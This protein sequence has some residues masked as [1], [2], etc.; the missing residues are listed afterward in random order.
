MSTIKVTITD[1]Q[2]LNLLTSAL[3]GG[4]NYWYL[5]DKDA[6][7]IIDKHFPPAK[8]VCFVDRMWATIK[9]GLS[10]PIADNEEDEGVGE[11][12][13]ASI[14]KGEQLLADK[15][16]GTLAEILEEND[17]A[18]TADIWFQLCSFGE[19]IYG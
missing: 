12:S 8:N 1:E 10:I 14:E 18:N 6:A 17:D 5:L 11:I 13:L 7:D 2:R 4:S 15:Y 19:V 3:E 9:A 16:P